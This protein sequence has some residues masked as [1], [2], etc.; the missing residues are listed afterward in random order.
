VKEDTKKWTN[1]GVRITEKRNI[2]FLK[3]NS[4]SESSNE[5]TVSETFDANAVLQEL[6]AYNK[7]VLSMLEQWDGGSNTVQ[8][9]KTNDTVPGTL[10]ATGNSNVGLMPETV[11]T[12]KELYAEKKDTIDYLEKFGSKREKAQAMV[13]KSVALGSCI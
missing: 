7:C 5:C 2:N 9:Y 8:D 12:F 13:I 6:K 10:T 1:E 11:S 4:L 3:D